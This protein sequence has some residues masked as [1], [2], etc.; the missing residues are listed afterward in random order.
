MLSL[1]ADVAEERP[2]LCVVE[3]A[4]WLDQA[5]AQALAIAARRLHAESV[6]VLFAI[7]EPCAAP[8]FEGLPELRAVGLPDRDA[9]ELL[10]SVTP[11]GLDARVRDRIV[12]E[13]HGGRGS[14]L[15]LRRGV[16][17]EV[18]R[19][20]GLPHPPDQPAAVVVTA[21]VA[22]DASER[23]AAAAAVVVG[24]L[25]FRQRHISR[26]I[27]HPYERTEDPCTPVRRVAP[28]GR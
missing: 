17:G 16:A 21:E 8:Q 4:Q 9:R 15:L 13:T 1:L 10:A 19:C 18:R 28:P 24:V 7:R 23:P 26:R 2:L 3:D 27:R 25:H 12:A 22:L 14:D 11:G 6:T 20:G 5:S